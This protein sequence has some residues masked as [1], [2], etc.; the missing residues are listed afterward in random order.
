MG[1]RNPAS[2]DDMQ[3]RLSKCGYSGV[4]V[5]ESGIPY[6]GKQKPLRAK[7]VRLRYQGAAIKDI[8]ILVGSV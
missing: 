5:W 6:Q 3:Q 4:R 8:G 1:P 7:K 2:P